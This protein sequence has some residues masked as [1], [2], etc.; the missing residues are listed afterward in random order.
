MAWGDGGYYGRLFLNVKGREPEG[1]IEPSR[2]DEVR[3]DLIAR[4]ESALGP[5]GRPLGTKVLKPQDVYPEVRG[6]APDLIVYFG[7][8]D[9][10]SVGTVGNPEVFTHENDTGP[11]GANHDPTGI[12]VM[13]G[14]AG[15]ASGR[16][17]G[18]NLVDV[19]PTILRMYG[20]EAP[21][22]VVGRNFQPGD[23]SDRR[24]GLAHASI[25]RPPSPG[26]RSTARIASVRTSTP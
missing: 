6:V 11:D 7:D 4:F 12:F 19:G 24:P 15:Q 21:E 18:M 3:N 9:W 8:L 14:A 16:V 25:A 1:V 23:L 17:E 10:R 20:I 5:D 22:G 26:S 13:H 2:Y